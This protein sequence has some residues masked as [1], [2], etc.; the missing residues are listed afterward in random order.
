MMSMTRQQRR[1]TEGDLTSTALTDFSGRA[2]NYLAKFTN[3]KVG[4]A[5]LV[6]TCHYPDRGT[7]SCQAQN[8]AHSKR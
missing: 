5:A 6:D 3:G 4:L 8:N 7:I 1:S 2:I